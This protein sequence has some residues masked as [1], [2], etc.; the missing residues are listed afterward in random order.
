MPVVGIIDPSWEAWKMDNVGFFPKWF[1]KDEL[2][3]SAVDAPAKWSAWPYELIKAVLNEQQE[4][5][6]ISSTMLVDGCYRAKVIER[7][8][9]F[10]ESLDNLYAAFRGTA[11]HR[12][13]EGAR[14]PNAIA[15]GR[16]WVTLD[17]PKAGPVEVSCS[18]D[19]VYSGHPGALVDYKTTE[20][21][22]PYGDPWPNHTQQLNV[23]R[24]LV[25]HAERWELPDGQELPWDPRD[26]SIKSLYIVYLTPKGPKVLEC[27][28]SQPFTLKNGN[29]T[30]RKQPYVWSDRGV[31]DFL[32]PR[33][34][35]MVRALDAYPKWPKGL[36]DYPG[37]AGPASWDCPGY[38]LCKLPN[39]LAKRYGK[40]GYFTWHKDGGEKP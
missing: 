2:L 34:E 31:E 27:V 33:L 28:K 29:D 3:E 18:P 13:L 14:R 1:T 10:V 20:S 24:Y 22:P 16:F 9:D 19:L 25:N 37:W 12:L 6:Y 26:L 32:L 4:R 5:D 30:M 8:E 36:E 35:A 40:G 17:V 39:C 7:R 21:P 38:P 15:E 11:I 23:N